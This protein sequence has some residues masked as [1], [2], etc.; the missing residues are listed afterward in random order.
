MRLATFH[1]IF[2]VKLPND[3]IMAHYQTLTQSGSANP[4]GRLH[5]TEH[6][7]VAVCSLRSQLLMALHDEE[8][9]DLCKADRCHILAGLGALRRCGFT[10]GQTRLLVDRYLLGRR[11]LPCVDPG[12][13]PLAFQHL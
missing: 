4:I 11:R 10:P 8:A 2:S 1:K 7:A 12:L 3:D 6:A 13:T 5:Y 9:L